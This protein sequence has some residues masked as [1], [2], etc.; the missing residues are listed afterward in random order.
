MSWRYFLTLPDGY[1]P[2]EQRSSSPNCAMGKTRAFK[3][4]GA[5]VERPGDPAARPRGPAGGD[6]A[7]QAPAPV[8][9][10]SK[11]PAYLARG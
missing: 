4:C 9:R 1:G 5:A 10:T 7:G 8:V 3:C 11:A 6:R 2:P